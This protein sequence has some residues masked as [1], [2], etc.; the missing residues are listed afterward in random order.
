MST[1][2]W[3]L[4]LGNTRLKMAP[5]LKGGRGELTALAHAD[6]TFEVALRAHFD[7][8]DGDEA[9]LASVA[10]LD[11]TSHLRSLLQD[12]GMEVQRV[13]TRASLGRL[14]IAYAEPSRL[15]VDR[16]LAM[17]GAVAREDGPW[18]LASAG[19]A[20][21]VDVLDRD[22]QHRGGLIAPMPAQMRSALA[23]RFAQLDVPEGSAA[24]FGCDTADAIASGARAAALGLLEHSFRRA[25][26]LLG[27]APTVLVGGGNAEWL[28]QAE[29]PGAQAAPGLVLD[30]MARYIKEAKD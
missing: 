6:E 23:T 28:M 18:L 4:D 25:S 1:K 22:G 17:L 11:T 2:H 21:T 24:D 26:A 12:L 13:H 5:L 27:K 16:F 19:S 29:V 3:L 14:K 7:A 8:H 9:W 30:G 10:P 15:G 20:L